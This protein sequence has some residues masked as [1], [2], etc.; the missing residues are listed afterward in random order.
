MRKEV[1]CFR[2]VKEYDFCLLKVNFHFIVISEV[3][4]IKKFVLHDGSLRWELEQMLFMEVGRTN[5]GINGDEV[6]LEF[7]YFKYG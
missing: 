2:E 7:D 1:H 5:E 4:Q 3:H 6:S